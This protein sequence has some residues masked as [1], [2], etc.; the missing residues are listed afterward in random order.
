[1]ANCP[2]HKTLELA[3]TT[4]HM[5]G[6]IDIL[7]GA[8]VFCKIIEDGL[9]KMRDGVVAQKTSFGWLLSGQKNEEIHTLVI[10]I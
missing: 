8:D 3:D 10:T 1:M 7:L 2:E 5:P 9:V 4:Y 6:T